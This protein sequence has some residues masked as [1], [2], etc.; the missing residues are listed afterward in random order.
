MFGQS[1]MFHVL[2]HPDAATEFEEAICWYAERSEQAAENFDQVVSQGLDEILQSPLRC[3]TI[4]GR[5]R[6][7]ILPKRFPY[8]ILYRVDA[9]SVTVIAVAHHHRKPS[10]WHGRA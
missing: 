7:F 10:Y 5:H 9:D 4:D 6:I 1:D 2:F 3:P 8:H